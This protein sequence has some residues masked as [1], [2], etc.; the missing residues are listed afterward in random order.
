MKK[1]KQPK[2]RK[3][4]AENVAARVAANQKAVYERTN[5]DA[6]MREGWVPGHPRPKV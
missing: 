2:P 6:A 5:I 4:I 1:R 3:S